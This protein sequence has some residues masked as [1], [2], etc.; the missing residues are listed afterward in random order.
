M[1]VVQLKK[2]KEATPDNSARI[3][4]FSLEI[5]IFIKLKQTIYVGRNSLNSKETCSSASGNELRATYE[6][7][8]EEELG[9]DLHPF[10]AECYKEN[11]E[12]YC[13]GNHVLQYLNFSCMLISLFYFK[14]FACP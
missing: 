14:M 1:R 9:P 6:K 2:V 4:R 8:A 11:K 12:I 3:V 13:Y 7:L 5:G 10:V